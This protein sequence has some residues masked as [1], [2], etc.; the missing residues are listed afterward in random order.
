MEHLVIDVGTPRSKNGS[1]NLQLHEINMN[2][3]SVLGEP[4]TQPEFA[5]ID[6]IVECIKIPL[7]SDDL[8][9]DQITFKIEKITLNSMTLPIIHRCA[10]TNFCFPTYVWLYNADKWMYYGK[11]LIVSEDDHSFF[12]QRKWWTNSFGD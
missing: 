8:I 7:Y 10:V 2:E 1:T 6:D 11:T 12:L 5:F 3:I 4:T 9:H